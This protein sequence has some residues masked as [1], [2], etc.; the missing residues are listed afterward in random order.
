LNRDIN[1]D[2][3]PTKVGS[4]VGSVLSSTQILLVTKA[5]MKKRDVGHLDVSIC[6]ILS[7]DNCK[8]TAGQ[9][10]INSMPR[11]CWHQRV[12]KALWLVS[13]RPWGRV[14]N[15]LCILHTAFVVN[16]MVKSNLLHG[17]TIWWNMSEC[18]NSC[19]VFDSHISKFLFEKPF[20]K[21]LWL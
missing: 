4:V 10:I 12:E 18:T 3:L 11:N 2:F 9:L 14:G 5:H 6:L 15:L 19:E 20:N 7:M 16:T 13:F 21:N 1:M 17:K 8:V